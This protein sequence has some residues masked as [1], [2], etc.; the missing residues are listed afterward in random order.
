MTRRESRR[1]EIARRE[2]LSQNKSYTVLT[3]GGEGFGPPTFWV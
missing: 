2:P 1:E 3:M